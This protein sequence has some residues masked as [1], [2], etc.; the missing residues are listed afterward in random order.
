MAINYKAIT[1]GEIE[2]VEDNRNIK[3]YFQYTM[4]FY[5]YF[6]RRVNRTFKF[7]TQYALHLV[8]RFLY[9]INILTDKIYAWSRNLFVKNATKNKSTI[10]HFWNHLKVYKREIDEEKE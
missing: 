3:L 7:V 10:T 8:V 4:A 9:I 2:I 5:K 1:K 6:I